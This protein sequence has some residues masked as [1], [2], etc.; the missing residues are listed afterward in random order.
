MVDFLGALCLNSLKLKRRGRTFLGG[1]SFGGHVFPHNASDVVTSHCIMGGW[2][3]LVPAVLFLWQ[4]PFFF[5]YDV[6]AQCYIQGKVRKM[7]T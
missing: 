4:W 7:V 5:S 2:L 3:P 1:R 6:L